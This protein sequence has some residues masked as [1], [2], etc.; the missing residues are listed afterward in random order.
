MASSRWGAISGVGVGLGVEV[1]R[2]AGVA[3]GGDGVAVEEGV[4]STVGVGLT[5]A[6]GSTSRSVHAAMRRSA[7][8]ATPRKTRYLAQRF[9]SIS[10]GLS[11]SLPIRSLPLQSYANCSFST[12]SASESAQ[13]NGG[14]QCYRGSARTAPPFSR[15]AASVRVSSSDVGE[16]RVPGRETLMPADAVAPRRA[17]G[18]LMPCAS[19]A[20]NAP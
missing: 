3:V 16:S 1:G 8:A 7:D 9:R 17:S 13:R 5:A 18:K 10:S 6:V 12:S 15:Q 19:R 4:A 2:G 14:A 11:V 20:A